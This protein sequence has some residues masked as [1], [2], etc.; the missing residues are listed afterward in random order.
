MKPHLRFLLFYAIFWLLLFCFSRALFL[1]YEFHQTVNLTFVTILKTFIYGFRL[2][3]S[4]TGYIILLTAVLMAVSEWM[5]KP[6]VRMVIFQSLTFLLLLV[7]GLIVMAD[8]ELYRNWGFRIDAMVLD[9]LMTPQ[10]AMASTPTSWVIAFLLGWLLFVGGAFFL[11]SRFLMPVVRSF[12]K[13]KW[14]QAALFIPIAATMILPIRGSL[15]VAPINAGSVYFS[16]DMYANHAAVNAVWNFN[17]SLL[18]RKE[19]NRL[20]VNWMDDD[21]AFQEVNGKMAL[22]RADSTALKLVT[23]PHPNLIVI[24]LESFSGTIIEP[25]GGVPHV[26]PNMSRFANEGVFFSNVYATG[27]RSDKGLV[28]ILSGY[29]AQVKASIMKYPKKTNGLTS[30]AKVLRSNGYSTTFYYG[31]DVNF[32]N[33]RSYMFGIGFQRIVAID[34]FDGALQNA[35]WGVH[36]EVTFN[37]LM[38]EMDTAQSPT[39]KTLFTL[40]SHE[41]FE[42]PV[43]PYFAN[44]T[45]VEKSINAFHYTDSCLGN[46]IDM[47]KTK[48][49]WKNT[50]VVLVADHCSLMPV[51][52]EINDPK[53]YHIPMIWLGG[54][55]TQS[56]VKIDKLMAQYDLP[57]TILQQMNF[58]TTDF[59][60]SRN[61]LGDHYRGEAVFANN[62]GIGYV[63]EGDTVIYDLKVKD[64]ILKSTTTPNAVDAAHAWFQTFMRDFEKR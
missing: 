53:R 31:G 24:V 11:F 33:M 4:L 52:M 1:A 34:D 55:L 37:R 8:L 59:T 9:Y 17:Y 15:D 14:W 19:D 3:A 26:T 21:K 49:W 62:D 36:D 51:S 50:I 46:F 39:F 48:P 56:P 32:A 38:T 30:I 47:A 61:A 13:L 58:P 45:E 63:A 25:L 41:P 28:A 40:T 16:N 2:D 22:N 18:K 6:K 12:E 5:A 23:V 60:F 44:N 43:K 54:A 57:G 29:P 20:N 64:D 42:I 10:L 27:N 35:K 7:T